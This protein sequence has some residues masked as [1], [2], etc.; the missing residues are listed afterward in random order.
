M[1]CNLYVGVNDFFNGISQNPMDNLRRNLKV[2]IQKCRAYD[3]GEVISS[4]IVYNTRIKLPQRGELSTTD[5]CFTRLCSPASAFYYDFAA[6]LQLLCNGRL[7]FC[8]NLL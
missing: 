8:I 5:Q 4:S 1:F 3:A 2:I 7:T 6:D